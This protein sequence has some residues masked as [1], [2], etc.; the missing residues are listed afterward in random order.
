MALGLTRTRTRI[1]TCGSTAKRCSRL[2]DT[3]REASFLGGRKQPSKKASWEH[4]IAMVTR[5][6]D[7]E[8]EE[9]F[10]NHKEKPG[11]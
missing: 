7:K 8:L 10:R 11:P 6:T 3:T 9:E 5:L 1:T 4:Y 2:E